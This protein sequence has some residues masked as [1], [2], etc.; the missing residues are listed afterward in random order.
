[1]LGSLA[2][3]FALI[4]PLLLAQ[5]ATPA[6]N[7]SSTLEN[8]PRTCGRAA[9]CCEMGCPVADK[10]CS[11]SIS[12]PIGQCLY[13]GVPVD[14]VVLTCSCVSSDPSYQTNCGDV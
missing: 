4:A 2:Q 13:N 8:C 12:S 1:M 7:L 3:V 6:P 14:L 9:R 5:P 10:N 11:A